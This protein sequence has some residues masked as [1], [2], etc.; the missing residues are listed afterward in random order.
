MTIHDALTAL[1]KAAPSD[2]TVPV[3]WIKELLAAD[4]QTLDSGRSDSDVD[5]TVKEVARRFGRGASTIRTW[6]ARG[7]LVGAYRLHGREW[8]VPLA[9]IDRLQRAQAEPVAAES[10]PQRF[11]RSPDVGE[12]RKHLA[13]R[14]SDR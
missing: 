9:S 11:T 7:E 8:R 10:M 4:D 2:A 13:S 14:P 1:V 12:W 6:L 5:L 3:R